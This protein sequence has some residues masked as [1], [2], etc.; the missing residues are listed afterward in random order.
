M[1]YFDDV[2]IDSKDIVAVLP[3][4]DSESAKA[5]VLLADGRVVST[6]VAASTLKKR[7]EGEALA[8]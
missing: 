7:L 4:K 8:P 5:A 6:L 1:L 2:R 3:V